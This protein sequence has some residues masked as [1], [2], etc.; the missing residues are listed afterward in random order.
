MESLLPVLQSHSW[1]MIVDL[2]EWLG[3]WTQYGVGHCVVLSNNFWPRIL[4]EQ[5]IKICKIKVRG[6]YGNNF[7]SQQIVDHCEGGIFIFVNLWFHIT[8]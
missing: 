7:S 1:D 8:T 2:D 3:A 5:V 4:T 6:N